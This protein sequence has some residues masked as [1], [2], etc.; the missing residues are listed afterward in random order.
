MSKLTRAQI[1]EVRRAFAN[2]ASI[3]NVADEFGLTY[4]GAQYHASKVG[5]DVT[6]ANSHPP[7][8][9]DVSW[10]AEAACLGQDPELFYPTAGRAGL[11]APGV[12][13]ALEL[14]QRCP[15]REACL[16]YALA[17]EEHAQWDCHGIYG[18]L[19]AR[20]RRQIIRAREAS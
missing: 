5:I 9:L 20:E 8:E 2:G 15:V 10:F 19:T 12:Q 17:F 3:R 11:D 1:H 18:G 4:T 14:C 13:R 16:D 6:R 7:T